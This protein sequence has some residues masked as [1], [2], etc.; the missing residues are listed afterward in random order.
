MLHIWRCLH[1][2]T[3][4]TRGGDDDDDDNDDHHHRHHHH[5][6]DD[7]DDDEDVC[8]HRFRNIVTL[9]HTYGRFSLAH[10]ES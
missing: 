7:D 8:L 9:V 1:A 6:D 10:K 2:S 5:D 4:P 3:R